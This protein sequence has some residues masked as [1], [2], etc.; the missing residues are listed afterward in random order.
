MYLQIPSQIA[1]KRPS[2]LRRCLRHVIAP[3]RISP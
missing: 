3:T 2:P 1:L